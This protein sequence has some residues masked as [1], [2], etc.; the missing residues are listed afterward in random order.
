MTN[1]LA[2]VIEDDEDL[3]VIFTK[4]LESAAF[5]VQPFAS[6]EAAWT[7]MEQ[8]APHIIVLDL[9]LP[10][11]SG[12][13]M[14]ADIKADGRF[15][16]TLVILATANHLMAQSLND[17]ADLV[18]IKPITFSQLRDLTSRLRETIITT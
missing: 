1:P 4:A 10:G 18:L 6:A 9:N 15:A 12:T 14:L 17:Q 16:D 13:A 7:F 11:K 2:M 3:A 8:T 5:D